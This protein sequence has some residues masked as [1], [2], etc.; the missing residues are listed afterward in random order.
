MLL[1]CFGAFPGSSSANWY[2][3][4]GGHFENTGAYALLRQEA[5]LDR[6]RRLRRRSGLPLLRPR[7]P[8]PARPHRPQRRDHF[9]EAAPGCRM[10]APGR[11]RFAQ[12]PGLADQ[13]GLPGAGAG[14]LRER[15]RPGRSCWS[16]PM[17]RPRCRWTWSTSRPP[18]PCSRSSPPPTSSSTRRS[19]RATSASAR[20]SASRL[21]EPRCW[22]TWR[23]GRPRPVRARR[24]PAAG[25]RRGAAQATSEAPDKDSA[26]AAAVG[27]MS[28]LQARVMRAGA[29]TASVG[30]GTAATFGVAAWQGIDSWRAQRADQEKAE[31]SAFKELTER[32]ARLHG[33]ASGGEA[34]GAAGRRTAAH[35]RPAVP[36]GPAT[37]SWPSSGC[38]C[39][40]WTTPSRPA[41]S[42]A[43]RAAHRRPARACSI[44]ATASTACSLR[45]RRPARRATGRATTPARSARSRTAAASCPR[46]GP[47]W[48]W[49][50]DRVQGLGVG[51]VAGGVWRVAC[52]RAGT[53]AV[54]GAVARARRPSRRTGRGAPTAAR[55]RRRLRPAR[56]VYI[57]TY[58]PGAARQGAQP[59]AAPGARWAPRCRRSRTC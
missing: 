1:E 56:V 49:L 53:A 25:S 41:R 48:C 18:T 28:R 15:R 13:P 6:D 47:R 23:D 22:S 27:S 17:C 42:E 44:P 43:R 57:Q 37:T 26:A 7:G 19:G 20:R 32:W 46:R 51:E 30:I 11:L 58:G 16:S 31:N 36:R 24:R 5:A 9:H 39:A 59:G 4:D 29:V 8:D 12:R 54:S 2:L 40:S 33:G 45:R 3:S 50:R 38:R 14:A 34:L 21:D 52:G 35:R 55:R 10:D